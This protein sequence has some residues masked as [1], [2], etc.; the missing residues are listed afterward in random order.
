MLSMERE[1]TD[2]DRDDAVLMK[3][4]VPAEWLDVL[5]GAV[6]CDIAEP[7]TFFNCYRLEAGRFHG[8]LR[9]W[10]GWRCIIR[11]PRHPSDPSIPSMPLA[12][13]AT[14][15]VNPIQEG[16]SCADP[17]LLPS[18]DFSGRRGRDRYC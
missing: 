3:S 11:R 15:G 17:A 8:N 18:S 5:V 16:T 1:K 14:F 7:G 10:E 13:T 6:A 12:G 2:F 4:V 9:I